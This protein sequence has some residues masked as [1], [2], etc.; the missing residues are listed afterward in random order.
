MR[1][2]EEKGKAKEKEA[3]RKNL[4]SVSAKVSKEIKSIQLSSDLSL[5]LPKNKN[6]KTKQGKT[7]QTKKTQNSPQGGKKKSNKI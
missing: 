2:W 3:V 5:F 4:V 6:P 7:Q 1:R